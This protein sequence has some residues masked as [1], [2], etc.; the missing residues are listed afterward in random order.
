MPESIPYL[1]AAL[2]TGL[3]LGLRHAL[4]ADHIAAMST[5]VS[6]AGGLRAS[7]RCGAIWGTGH[8][9]TLFLTGI[10]ILGF[11][12]SIPDSVASGLDVIVGMMLVWLG[13]VLVR[14]V[15]RMRRR[16]RNDSPSSHVHESGWHRMG[17]RSFVVGAV[18]GLAGSAAL[19]LLILSTMESM[20]LGL[21][22]ILFFGIGS[23]AGMLFFSGALALPLAWSRGSGRMETAIRLSAATVSVAVGVFV[24]LEHT[25]G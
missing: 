24:I 17:M 13:A 7:L 23:I 9:A 22:Y 19:L 12:L 18:H 10:L 2:G 1:V 15:M 21:A 3:L 25:I 5:L 11:K 8:T 4:D 16:E 20:T 6:R 14:D